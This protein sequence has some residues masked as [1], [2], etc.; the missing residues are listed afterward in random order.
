MCFIANYIVFRRESELINII[1]FFMLFIGV[2]S[3]F[4]FHLAEL[5]FVTYGIYYF[6]NNKRLWINR[7][8]LLFLLF[9]WFNNS[10]KKEYY[11]DVDKFRGFSS[12]FFSDVSISLYALKIL[13]LINGIIYFYKNYKNRI[14]VEKITINFCIS[15]ILILL[16]GFMGATNP[17]ANFLNYYFFGQ[18]KFGIDRGNLFQLNEWGERMAWR[19]FFQV[20]KQLVNYLL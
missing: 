11:L 6:L 13:F 19:G 10:Y 16:F 17:L 12:I 4:N 5:V 8:Y 7:Y 15:S 20:Q 2:F 14:D 3:G 9:L 1:P 18:N